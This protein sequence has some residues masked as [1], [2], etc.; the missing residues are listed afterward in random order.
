MGLSSKT[1]HW[2]FGKAVKHFRQKAGM[3]Q[4]DLWRASG[5]HWTEISHL[6]SGR[7]NPSLD[8]IKKLCKGLGVSRWQLIWM[9]ELFELGS[10]SELS[11]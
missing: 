3:T 11:G 10:E 5:L 4:E 6:E 7:R 9:E 1:P 2:A 8:T